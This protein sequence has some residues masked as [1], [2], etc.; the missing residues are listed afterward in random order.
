MEKLSKREV[1][2]EAIRLIEKVKDPYPMMDLNLDVRRFRNKIL[3]AEIMPAWEVEECVARL[4]DFLL[5]F[6]NVQ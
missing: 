5:D 1:L 4:H 2:D 3:A 6:N